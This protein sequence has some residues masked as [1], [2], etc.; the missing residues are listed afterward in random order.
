MKASLL[1]L[2]LFLLVGCSSQVSK[3]PHPKTF[4]ETSWGMSKEEVLEVETAKRLP[5]GDDG[6]LYFEGQLDYQTVYIIYYFYKDKLVR[7]RYWVSNYP[8]HLTKVE[9]PNFS[10]SF[11]NKL[12]DEL[13]KKYGKPNKNESDSLR[14]AYEWEIANTRIEMDADELRMYVDYESPELVDQMNK[15]KDVPLNKQL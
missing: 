5:K 9:G 12:A 4:R 11:A 14:L 6:T 10:V 1:A 7:G 2:V 15:E 3:Q 13:H 8:S